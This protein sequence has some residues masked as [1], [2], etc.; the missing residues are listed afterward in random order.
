MSTLPDESFAS[1][2]QWVKENIIVG[3]ILGSPL[4]STEKKFAKE[5]GIKNIDR[6]RVLKVNAI[7]PLPDELQEIAELYLNTDN[8]A[9]ITFGHVIFTIKN[10]DFYNELVKHELIHVLQV[11]RCGGL[12]KFL[13]EYISQVLLHGYENAPMEIE[14]RNHG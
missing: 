1:I 5:V 8:S 10:C 7:R 4:T 2:I 13:Q 12:E 14:A 11:E 3:E 9:G 6:I